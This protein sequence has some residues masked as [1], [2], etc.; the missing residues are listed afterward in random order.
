MSIILREDARMQER[1]NTRIRL[2]ACICGLYCVCANEPAAYKIYMY[3][4]SAINIVERVC[5]VK[6]YCE[7]SCA[8]PLADWRKRRHR[9]LAPKVV[10]S[11]V[12][13]STRYTLQPHVCRHVKH[14]SASSTHLRSRRRLS[15]GGCVF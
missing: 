13:R 9:L 10:P 15:C 3:A 8:A 11:P 1:T 2:V 12:D 4:Q 5:I 7:G 14:C 6:L